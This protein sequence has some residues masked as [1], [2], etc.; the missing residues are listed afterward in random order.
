MAIIEPV[1]RPPAEAGSFLLQVTLGCSSYTCSF[2]GAY[3]NKPFQV[4]NPKEITADINWYAARYPDTRR[5]FLMDGDALVLG[6]SKLVPILKEL[7][8]AFPLLSR[9]AS[10]AS[11]D[12]LVR[13]T[14]AELAELAAERL[15]LIYL[16]LES[17]SQDILHRCG[18]TSSVEGMIDGV[19]RAAR[20]NIKSSVIVLLG[21]GGKARSAEHVQGTI[22]ALNRM[23]PRYLSFL[24]LMVIPGT[25]LAKEVR[26]GK[27][28]ELSPRE[29]LQESRD[30][31]AGLDLHKTVFRSDHASN[32][33][34]L[35]GVFPKDK[36]LLLRALRAALDGE[37]ALRPEFFRGL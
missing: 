36:A 20:A 34:A 30:I 10:Y 35:E 22:T 24:S 23:Q 1:I 25:A 37:T 17:G 5:V 3:Q 16:G 26:G 32:H 9:V 4:K 27:F 6:N 8:V 31:I 28:Q 15:S 13:K 18:K 11:G 21:L 19:N 7:Q 12:N 14:D 2:C 29:L 33:L